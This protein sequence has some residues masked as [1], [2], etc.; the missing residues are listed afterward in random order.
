MYFQPVVLDK[1]TDDLRTS[2]RRFLKSTLP[3]GRVPALGIAAPHDPEFSAMLGER[4]WIGM[5][6][7]AKYG[8]GDRTAV[9]RFVVIEELLAAGAPVGAHWIADRQTAPLLLK[10][11]SEHLRTRFLPEIVKGTCWFSIGMSEPDAGSDLASVRTKADRVESGWILN[12]AKMWTT[13]AHKSHY[14]IV[15]CR[16]SPVEGNRHAGLSQLVVDLKAP[17]V[18]INPIRFLD[19]SHELNE[20]VLTDVFVPDEMVVGEV[21]QGWAQVTSELAHERAGPDRY[22]SGYQLL[23]QLVACR[24]QLAREHAAELGRLASWLATLRQ[25]SLYVAASIDAGRVPAVQAAMV[26]DLGT[27]YEQETVT[28]MQRLTGEP[29]A[30]GRNADLFASLLAQATLFAPSFTI[31]GG[32]NEVLRGIVARG[33]G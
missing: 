4:G 26:K 6:I 29:L 11:G 27:L 31:R 3:A 8:G 10:F 22:M 19:G 25:M 14:F 21:G 23:E 5:A 24:P 13:W 16:T 30:M 28:T 17:G 9:E 33:L 12:G 7:P 2:V 15:L 32:T 20:V 18:T 1:Q